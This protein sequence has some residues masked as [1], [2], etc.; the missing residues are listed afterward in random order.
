MQPAYPNF[1]PVKYRQPL[2]IV[3]ILGLIVAVYLIGKRLK[4][5]DRPKLDGEDVSTDPSKPAPRSGFS[6]ANEVSKLAD[7]FSQTWDGEGQDEQA[8]NIILKYGDNETKLVHNEWRRKYAGGNYWG[9]IK[10]TLRAQVNAETLWFY[11]STAIALKKKVI[12]K[13]DRLNL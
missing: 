5:W 2:N 12:A 6:P 9:G 3:L 11:R 4:I 1:V 10:S 13:L 8:F 7:L